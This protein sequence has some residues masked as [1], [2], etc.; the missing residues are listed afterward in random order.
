MNNSKQ[1]YNLLIVEGPA[2]KRFLEEYLLYL[3][4][5]VIEYGKEVGN[6]KDY[7]SIL[8]CGG[9]DKIIKITSNIKEHNDYNKNKDIKCAII[10]DADLNNN[11]NDS[12]KYIDDYLNNNNLQANVFLFPNNKDVGDLE[13]LLEK[14][15]NSDKQGILDCFESY[16]KCL[17]TLKDIQTFT[18]AKKSKIYSYLEVQYDTNEKRK[19]AKEVERNYRNI[20]FWNLQNNALD[21][22]K[23][24]LLN[25]MFL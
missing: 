14:I 23:D 12:K 11:Y 25:K 1:N 13:T 16:E 3:K 15:I 4:K 5:N 6:G 24:F 2:D 7:Y 21:D 10:F 20:N 8:S 18:P 22:L 9:R 19:L 17:S